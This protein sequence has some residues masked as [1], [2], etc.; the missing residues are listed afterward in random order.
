[1]KAASQDIAACKSTALEVRAQMVAEM[2]SKLVKGFTKI[3][4]AGDAQE[5]TDGIVADATKDAASK[6]SRSSALTGDIKWLYPGTATNEQNLS[7]A[8]A[9]FT[10]S[11]ALPEGA[12]AKPKS[13]KILALAKHIGAGFTPPGRAQVER[14]GRRRRRRRR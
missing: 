7:M 14:R 8:I 11:E 1:V 6:C 2:A 3:K 5:A 13:I 12:A 10:H 9:D 4:L